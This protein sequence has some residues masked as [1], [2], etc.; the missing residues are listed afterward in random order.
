MAG[1]LDVFMEANGFVAPGDGYDITLVAADCAPL[2]ASNGLRISA[3]LAFSDANKPW[4]L[5]LVA[6]GPGLPTAEADPQL[7]EW[8]ANAALQAG[9]Y[10]RCAPGHLRSAMQACLTTR[11]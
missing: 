11:R 2:R 6:G 1:P 4:D 8:L 3:D 10:V 5:V 9:R 7:T